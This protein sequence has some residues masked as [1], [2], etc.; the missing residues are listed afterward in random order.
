MLF[1]EQK[2]DKTSEPL[3][4]RERDLKFIH[5]NHNFEFNV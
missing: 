3:H 2:V 5:W 4:V 1:Y